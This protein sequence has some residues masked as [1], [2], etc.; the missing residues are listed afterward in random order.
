DPPAAR[1]LLDQAI[2]LEDSGTELMGLK[3]W[4]SPV[5]PR[6]FDWAFNRKRGPEIAAH[7][8]KIP[9]Q[10]DILLVHT[11]P[12]GLLDVVWPGRHVG[13]EAL[14]AELEQRLHPRLLVCGHIHEA[15]GQA[16]LGP[17]QLIN[18]A[19]LDRRYRPIQ[20]IWIVDIEDGKIKEVGA[21]D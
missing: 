4:G 20:P 7:W 21:R 10:T 12:H 17:I 15:A 1:A 16:R 6:Y 11:P 19:S 9:T 2:Y 13:C 3:I 18:A 5:S 8:A 14:S